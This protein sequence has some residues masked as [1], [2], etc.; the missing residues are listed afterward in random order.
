MKYIS[1]II[2]FSTYLLSVE[3]GT[4]RN[5]T[6]FNQLSQNENK[7]N[8][9]L[10]QEIERNIYTQLKKISYYQK[11]IGDIS[12]LEIKISKL[13]K[14]KLD[15]KKLSKLDNMTSELKIREQSL[16]NSINKSKETIKILETLKRKIKG[17][18]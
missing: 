10:I 7:S 11:K 15:N 12:S 2:L 13:D 1:F 16:N 8:I 14:S 9:N 18:R 6:L 4:A 17:R 3:Y 5:E